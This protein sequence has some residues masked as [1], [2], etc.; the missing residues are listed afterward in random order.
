MTCA[1]I[2][3]GHFYQPPRENPWTGSIDRE[4]SAAPAHDWNERIFHEC[5][6]SN[7]YARVF[8]GQRI[9]RI[10][11]NYSYLNFNVG[12][13]LMS[14]MQAQQPETY[15][16]ILEADRQSRERLGHGNAIAQGFNHTILPL[17]N[18]RDRI[19]QV[20]WGLRDFSLRFGRE[21]ASLWLP[22]TAVD[23]KTLGT[24][25]DEGL[26]YVILE[27][28]QA[29]RVRPL[30]GPDGVAKPWQSVG[31]GSID[32]GIAYRYFHQD[33]SGRH[34]DVFFYDGPKSRA[35]A[36]EGVLS[37][38]RRFIDRLTAGVPAGRLVHVA[39]DGE[40]YGHHSRF[41]E[42]CLAHALTEE[43]HGRS[44]TVTN[45]AAYLEANPP[46]FEVEIKGG[47][48]TAWSCAH[49][50]GR[51]IR[52]CG[53]NTGAQPG[54]NQAWRG[55]LRDALDGLRDVLAAG[56]A[57]AAGDIFADPWAAR[58]AYV[59][60]LVDPSVS[61]AAWCDQ[62]AGRKLSRA[63]R[64]RALTLLEVQ[65]NAMLMYTSCGWF[66]ADLS[67]IE[68]VQIMKYAERALELAETA[69]LAAPRS[70]FVEQL[71]EAKSNLPEQ[72][73]G[74]DI[75]HRYV[76]P[77]RVTSA[78]VAAH[79]GILGLVDANEVE[80][81]AA[82]WRFVRTKARKERH[83]RLSLT[84]AR[85]ALEDTTTTRRADFAVASMHLGG[86]DFF[87]VCRPYPGD[88]AFE[89]STT[90]LW[91]RFR[92]ASLP[93]LIRVAQDEFGPT[94]FG[95]ES[96]LEGERHRISTLVQGTVVSRLC[97]QYETMFETNQRLLE[98]L[99]EAGLELPDELLRAAEFTLARRF[100][101]EVVKACE[102]PE[103]KAFARALEIAK[104]AGRRGFQLDR[105]QAGRA[106][107][108]M[109]AEQVASALQNPRLE[110]FEAARELAELTEPLGLSP[111]LARAQELV[112]EGSVTRPDWIDLLRP[113]AH[114]VAVDLP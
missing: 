77:L 93:R 15:A 101:S 11:N 49:G 24:L 17:C 87:S 43:A 45:Y 47:E 18:E 103:P 46:Q 90:R 19:T 86:V 12:P 102:K 100:N 36:F 56:Y 7:A 16:R 75:Y 109:V 111:T 8:A 26:S 21:A 20:R 5:Y 98:M 80:G 63:E 57:E 29:E 53:C 108:Q 76:A 27:P 66:F 3:H 60:V 2:I 55:P 28:H 23:H 40:S 32:P 104:E 62:Q 38:S 52:D 34:I 61:K 22:E 59:D 99:Q 78:R 105:T 70:A 48:G 81:E 92:V 110:A 83:G 74:A 10:V 107:G 89:I 68:T 106:F 64:E 114:A 72:G 51:W 1:L 33:G 30:P 97:E 42:M 65:R 82:G 95:L 79:L 113:L 6:R 44:V 85:L 67:G 71:A 94:E 41:A 50:V 96:L 14:W 39:T 84:T 35:I 88:E 58:N 54:W 73:S 112:Y 13:T 31:D 69:G 4:P 91:S 25:I 9:R 37:S